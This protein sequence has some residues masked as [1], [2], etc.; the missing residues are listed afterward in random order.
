MLES[1]IN[2]GK[3]KLVNPNG[4]KYGVSITDCC[5]DL[6]ETEELMKLAH[7]ILLNC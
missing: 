4:L 1:N 6:V 7:N 5:I 3:Q 2:S